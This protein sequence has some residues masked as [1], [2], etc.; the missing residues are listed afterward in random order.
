MSKAKIIPYPTAGNRTWDFVIR[1]RCFVYE[2]SLSVRLFI[3]SFAFFFTFFVCV[4]SLFVRLFNVCVC[5]F[6]YVFRCFVYGTSLSVRLFD[7][8]ICC[9]LLFF[10][11]VFLVQ[12]FFR[13]HFVFIWFSM[14]S[15]ISLWLNVSCSLTDVFWRRQQLVLTGELLSYLKQGVKRE[16]K[17]ERNNQ[18]QKGSIP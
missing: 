12:F 3:S 16:M 11:T 10:K 7:V 8:C 13:D 4:T 14:K 2:T 5:S 9:F 18:N 17:N 1:F 6:L 15:S